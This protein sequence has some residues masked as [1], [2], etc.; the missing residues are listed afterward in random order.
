M[1]IKFNLYLDVSIKIF[2]VELKI[3]SKLIDNY[4]YLFNSLLTIYFFYLWLKITIIDEL[5]K[6]YSEIF[7]LASRL[8]Q[9]L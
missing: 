7:G 8:W 9:D 4:S 1:T 3:T 2:I 5:T 6:M